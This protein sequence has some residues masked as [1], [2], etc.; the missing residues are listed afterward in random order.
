MSR[1]E[2]DRYRCYLHNAT[3]D[4]QYFIITHNTIVMG[5]ANQ[6]LGVGYVSNQMSQIVSFTSGF[7]IVKQ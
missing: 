5:D 7:P 1:E 2:I 3:T 4:A 6:R